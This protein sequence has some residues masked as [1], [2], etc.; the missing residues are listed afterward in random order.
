MN[1][2]SLTERRILKNVKEGN[3]LLSSVSKIDKQ[4]YH[5]FHFLKNN[6][7]FFIEKEIEINHEGL[8]FIGIMTNDI[9]TIE[10]QK[11]SISE[12]MLRIER[13]QEIIFQKMYD[14]QKYSKV[15]FKQFTDCFF[16]IYYQK[17]TYKNQ[18]I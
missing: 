7:Q 13:N 12:V 17:E 3:E 5:I 4:M 10:Y 14:V 6:P 2:I 1:I 11:L 9:F 8:F 15:V 16:D 18:L